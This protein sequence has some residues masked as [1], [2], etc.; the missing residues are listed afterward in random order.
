[1][2]S[3]KIHVENLKKRIQDCHGNG[4]EYEVPFKGKATPEKVMKWINDTQDN[5]NGGM[6]LKIKMNR[7]FSF[8]KK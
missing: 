5:N 4:K 2:S 6:L 1:M 3:T 7:Y 8:S